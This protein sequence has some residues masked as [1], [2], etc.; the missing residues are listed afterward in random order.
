[1]ADEDARRAAVKKA[2]LEIQQEFDGDHI[3]TAGRTLIE[4]IIRENVYGKAF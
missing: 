4:G 3:G 1:L 2:A